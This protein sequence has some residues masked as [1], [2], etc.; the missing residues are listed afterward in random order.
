MNVHYISQK[1]MHLN[2]FKKYNVLKQIYLLLA[3]GFVCT[4]SAQ[5]IHYSQFYNAPF[6]LNPGLTGIFGGEV[7]LTGNF[8]NQWRRVPVDYTTFSAAVD[9]KFI[10]RTARKDFLS[11]GL[12]FNHDQ[13]GY[14]KLQLV[15]LGLNGAYTYMLDDN[16][17]G[18]IGAQLG[19]NSRRFKTGAL[20]FDE[21][22]DPYQGVYVPG[23]PTGENFPTTSNFFLDFALGINFRLQALDRFELVDRLVRR[24]KMDFGVGIFHLNQPDQSFFEDEKVKLPVRLS[25]YFMGV[26]QLGQTFDLAGNIYAQ[27]QN[28][29]QEFLGMLG[30]KIHISRT[31]GK[32]FAVQPGIGYRFNDAFGDAWI[33]NLEATYNNWRLG[34]SYD[35]N[36]SDFKI[37]TD[38]R[39]GPEVSLQYLFKRVRPLPHFKF[40]PLI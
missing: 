32:Q 37:A 36:R 20:T 40:C 19:V 35:L 28:P 18:T 38:K 13:A 16:F 23:S 17:F 25:P 7:R 33:P 2:A 11:A 6:T 27:F 9:M 26:L 21:Q 29:Y 15:N 3:L 24:S 34:F 31:L 5:D 14:S 12:A 39:G 1:H 4:L 30:L 10:N 22:F 8:R